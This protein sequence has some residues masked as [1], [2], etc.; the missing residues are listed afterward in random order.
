MRLMKNAVYP[1]MRLMRK[2]QFWLRLSS[3]Y[4]LLRRS[5]RSPAWPYP[6]SRR[7]DSIKN[8]ENGTTESPT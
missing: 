8:Q 6:P 4:H 5:G 2:P 1:E 7:D 3:V